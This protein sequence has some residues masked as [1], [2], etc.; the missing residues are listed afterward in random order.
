MYLVVKVVMEMEGGFKMS[1]FNYHYEVEVN[2]SNCQA[3]STIKIPKG[4]TIR[5][6]LDKRKGKCPSCGCITIYTKNLNSNDKD[7]E[8]EKEERIRKVGGRFDA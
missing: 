3:K 5:S 2:C 1:L 6:W 8:E 4:T 7:D